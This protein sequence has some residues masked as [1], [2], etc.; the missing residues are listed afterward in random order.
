MTLVIDESE[1]ISWDLLSPLLASV[2]NEIRIFHL[3]SGN[4]GRELSLIVLLCLYI[5]SKK[6]CS[7]WVLLWMTIPILSLLYVKVGQ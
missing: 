3:F 1:E 6:Q 5:I 7:L 2:K 4:W